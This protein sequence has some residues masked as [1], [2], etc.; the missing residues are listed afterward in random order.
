MAYPLQEKKIFLKQ[1]LDVI[2][3]SDKVMKF[4]KEKDYNRHTVR[5]PL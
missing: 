1:Y 3:R 5:L 2:C 4:K